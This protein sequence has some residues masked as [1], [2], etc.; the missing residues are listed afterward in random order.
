MPSFRKKATVVFPYGFRRC[1]V[2]APKGTLLKK[3][4]IT[5]VKPSSCISKKRQIKDTLAKRVRNNSSSPLGCHMPKLPQ[6]SANQLL[7]V[8]FKIGFKT[9][10]QKGSH[11][12]LQRTI[13][14]RVQ[15]IIVPNHRSIRKG[16]LK[17][18]ILNQIPLSVE[19]L[20]ALL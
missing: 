4:P 9:V 20:L 6:I 8:L 5:F 10:S 11:I 16:T 13:N 17:N 18:G 12:K 7:R 2:A 1:R 14:K 19:E 3:P 15:T